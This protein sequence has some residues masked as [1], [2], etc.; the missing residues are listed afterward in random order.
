MPT[1]AIGRHD[2]TV[3]PT[4]PASANSRTSEIIGNRLARAKLP[5]RGRCSLHGRG[6]GSVRAGGGRT[7]PSLISDLPSLPNCAPEVF[8]HARRRIFVVHICNVFAY[9]LRVL[10]SGHRKCGKATG[11]GRRCTDATRDF[12]GRPS[13]RA[14][15]NL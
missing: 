9:H 1:V 12:S 14:F 15:S 2:D 11:R 5:I 13:D 7:P 10:E 4:P 8:I 6:E 3:V